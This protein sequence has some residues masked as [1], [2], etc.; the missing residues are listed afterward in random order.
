M[1]S[2]A[3]GWPR[4]FTNIFLPLS[5]SGCTGRGCAGTLSPTTLV[6]VAQGIEA[7]LMPPRVRRYLQIAREIGQL[8]DFR[9]QNGRLHI[10]M[11]ILRNG[12]GGFPVSAAFR[13]GGPHHLP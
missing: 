10:E 6:P 11:L 1:V 5:C 3:V 4:S 8:L 9:R 2:S 12:I 13:D 7:H